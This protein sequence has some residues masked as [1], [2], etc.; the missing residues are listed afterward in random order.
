M[1][2][3]FEANLWFAYLLLTLAIVV[4]GLVVWYQNRDGGVWYKPWVWRCWLCGFECNRWA[5]EAIVAHKR[6]EVLETIGHLK[7]QY[8]SERAEQLVRHLLIIERK[9]LL[10][11]FGKE[12]V[13]APDRGSK[14]DAL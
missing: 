2:E 6:E 8:P 3:W 14:A 13:N 1:E 10:Q 5:K 9:W 7:A 12:E 11:C 4:P